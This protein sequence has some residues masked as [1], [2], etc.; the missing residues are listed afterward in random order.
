MRD[1]SAK[2]YVCVYGLSSPLPGMIY[3]KVTTI[4]FKMG[5]PKQIGSIKLREFFKNILKIFT[6]VL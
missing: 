1:L 2:V 5:L 4:W 3:K 6:S